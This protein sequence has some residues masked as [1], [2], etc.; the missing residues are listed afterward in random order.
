MVVGTVPLIF[1]FLLGMLCM[2][3]IRHCER[4]FV[5]S[6]AQ[7]DEARLI[8][9]VE[10]CERIADNTFEVGKQV[11]RTEDRLSK[12]ITKGREDVLVLRADHDDILREIKTLID[13]R[14]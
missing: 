4:R 13:A 7:G 10:R 6:S 5:E 9:L 1:A 8:A 14:S 3:F 12:Q 2:V 11:A